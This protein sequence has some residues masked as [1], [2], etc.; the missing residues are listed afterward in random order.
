MIAGR[1]RHLALGDAA[2]L[3]AIIA[4]ESVYRDTLLL[5]YPSLARLRDNLPKL[6]QADD[7]HLIY[8]SASG[9]VLGRAGLGLAAK[10]SH[11][12]QAE[13]SIIVHPDWQGRG[14]GSRLVAE[15]MDVADSWMGLRRIVL[16]VYADN[17][18]AIA[19]YRKFGFV[20]EA[21]LRAASFRDGAY[22]DELIMAR[23]RAV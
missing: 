9:Q 15:L 18:R 4:D 17:H 2:A 20:E 1:I 10:S 13:L 6:L 14:I 19:L 12:N 8:E 21:R 11:W 5:P 22:C 23:V 16:K 3:H 7:C